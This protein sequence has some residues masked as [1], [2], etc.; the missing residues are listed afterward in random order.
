MNDMRSVEAD[1]I[2]A[3][4]GAKPRRNPTTKESSLW[5]DLGHGDDAESQE[6]IAKRY[7]VT[8]QNFW[9][10]DYFPTEIKGGR[11]GRLFELL[12]ITAAK[13]RRFTVSHLLAV[14]ERGQ[15]FAPQHSS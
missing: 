2:A 7:N 10:A 6:E 14:I 15:W 1:V 11:F 8:I 5:H 12:E 9:F 13:H 4:D 3:I